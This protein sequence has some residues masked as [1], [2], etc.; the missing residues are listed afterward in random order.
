MGVRGGYTAH[1]MRRARWL[2]PWKDSTERPVIYHCITRVVDRRFAFGRRR[3]S[4]SGPTADVGEFLG[5]P[6]A[7]VLPDGQPRSFAAGGAAAAGGRVVRRELLNRLGAI[8]HEAEVAVVAKE[9]AE[10]RQKMRD[11]LAD[12][13]VTGIHERYTYRMH[14]LGEFMKTLLQRFTRWFNA[15][16]ER[17]GA[18]WECRFKSVLVEDGIAARWRPISI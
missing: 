8:Y 6:G 2:A 12:E 1:V 14:D 3:R 9:L 10:A 7:G 11:G 13:R 16:H 18:L 5:L 17:T 4:N 15:K